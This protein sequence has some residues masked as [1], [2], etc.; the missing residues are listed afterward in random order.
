[1]GCVITSG[2]APGTTVIAF[3]V[4]D[5][6]QVPDGVTHVAVKVLASVGE[7]V[8]EFPVCPFDHVSIPATQVPLKTA[9]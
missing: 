1:M 2:K 5:T 4:S 3:E 7:T 6:W 9:D 8:N